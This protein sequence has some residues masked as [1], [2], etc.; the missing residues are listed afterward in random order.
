IR[1]SVHFQR[2][3]AAMLLQGGSTKLEQLFMRKEFSVFRKNASSLAA[4]PAQRLDPRGIESASLVFAVELLVDRD[5]LQRGLQPIAIQVFDSQLERWTKL[6]F[7]FQD[8]H[9]PIFIEL[10]DAPVDVAALDDDVREV[11]A[12][13][14]HVAQIVERTGILGDR[15]PVEDGALFDI[16]KSSF[17]GCHGL[18]ISPRRKAPLMDYI[19]RGNG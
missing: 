19:T 7:L 4:V 12:E 13:H 9:P 5:C 17:G 8:E 1:L 15:R 14:R 16:D 10:R 3:L 18:R 2:F 6:D 11:K